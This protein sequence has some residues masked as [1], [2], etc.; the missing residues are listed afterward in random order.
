MRKWR[1][2]EAAHVLRSD[3]WQVLYGTQTQ[4]CEFNQVRFSA[5]SPFF[6]LSFLFTPNYAMLIDSLCSNE[7]SQTFL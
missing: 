3:C 2:R 7:L 1:P 4:V 6:L 5:H